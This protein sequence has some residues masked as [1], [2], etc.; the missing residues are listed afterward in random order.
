MRNLRWLNE[1]VTGARPPTCE[2]SCQPGVQIIPKLL[3]PELRGHTQVPEYSP[4]TLSPSMLAVSVR[5]FI[6]QQGIR[7]DNIEFLLSGSEINILYLSF[8]TY[9]TKKKLM[10]KQIKATCLSGRAEIDIHQFGKATI[11]LPVQ[12]IL[13]ESVC[14][15][16]QAPLVCDS[17]YICQ[18]ACMLS[19]LRHV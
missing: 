11:Q 5:Q 6:Y 16:L 2:W 8:K 3:G 1:A 18:F 19:Y 12:A 14:R 17:F 9:F 4:V 10:H 7:A 13:E 15:C